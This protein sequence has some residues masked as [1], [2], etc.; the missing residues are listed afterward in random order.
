MVRDVTAP[1]RPAVKEVTDKDT[2]VMGQAE[3]GSKVE[4][5]VNGSVIGTGRAGEDGG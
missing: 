4:V 1:E 5:K 2:S 3:A